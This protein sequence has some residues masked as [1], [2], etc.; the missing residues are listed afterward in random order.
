MEKNKFLIYAAGCFRGV[1]TSFMGIIIA[2]YCDSIGLSSSQIGILITLGLAGG[3]GATLIVSLLGDRMG[4]R[5]TLIVLAFFSALGGIGLFATQHFLLLCL[6]VFFGMV[7]GMGRDRMAAFTLEQAILS[8]TPG[9]QARTKAF[10][11]YNFILDMGNGIGSLLGGLP[12]FFR[13][14]FHQSEMTSYQMTFIFYAILMIASGLIYTRLSPD[15]EI[16]QEHFQILSKQ[17]KKNI[18]RFSSISLMDAI[19]GG[20]L[21]SAL[22]AYWFFKKICR[23]I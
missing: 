8:S 1:S 4:R 9:L 22:I 14:F 11:S 21:T 12:I 13:N 17:S 6:V 19:G 23:L 10:A 2:I 3:T 5:R 15:I 18:L 7:N 16:K 20:F